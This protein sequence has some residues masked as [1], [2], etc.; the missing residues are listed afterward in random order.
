MNS[1][2]KS[3][4]PLTNLVRKPHVTHQGVIF[5]ENLAL[6]SP[7]SKKRRATDMANYISKNKNKTSKMIISSESTDDEDERI[8]ETPEANLQI[9]TSAPSQTVIIPPEDLFAKSFSEDVTARN[10]RY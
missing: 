5:H 3:R 8:P 1:K 4:S 7:S 9:D 10:F 6:V 2:H